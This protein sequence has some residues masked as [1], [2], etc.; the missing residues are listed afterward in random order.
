MDIIKDGKYVEACY[1][2]TVG[3]EEE[4]YPCPEAV[5]LWRKKPSKL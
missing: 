1:V 4:I 5:T 3:E 2:L